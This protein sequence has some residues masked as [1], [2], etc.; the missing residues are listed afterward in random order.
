MTSLMKANAH[1]YYV[2]FVYECINFHLPYVCMRY[3]FLPQ[4]NFN[5]KAQ[6]YMSSYNHSIIASWHH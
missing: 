1:H 4:A 6:S 2:A 3:H 5:W